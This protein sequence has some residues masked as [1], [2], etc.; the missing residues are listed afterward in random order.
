MDIAIVGMACL[1]PGA[2]DIKRY[3][4]NIINKVDAIGD[5]PED[6]GG[7]FYFDPNSADNDRIYCKRGGYLGDI[8]RFDPLDYGIIPMAVDG[9]EPEHFLALRVAHEALKDAGFPDIPINRDRTEVILGRGTFINRGYTTLHQHGLF[10]D[11]FL[12]L[13]K[14][15]HPGYTQEDL[16]LL[17]QR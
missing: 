16:K 17:K 3:W 10:I 12:C 15:L 6:W 9:A 1:F 8:S 7:E 13:L 14:E 5:P 2:Q 11:Q 4:Q